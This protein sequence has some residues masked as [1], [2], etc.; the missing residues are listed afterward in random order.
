M[1][2]KRQRGRRKKEFFP[3]TQ[4]QKNDTR[5]LSKTLLVFFQQQTEPVSLKTI[6]KELA[7]IEPSKKLLKETLADL[8]NNGKLCRQRQRWSIAKRQVKRQVKRQ[9]LVRAT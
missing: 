2:K 6:L 7:P 5:S 4:Q 1:A 8:E 3:P 9:K